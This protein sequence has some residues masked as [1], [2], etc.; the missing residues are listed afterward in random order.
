MALTHEDIARVAH[1]ANR[2]YQ[3]AAGDPAPSPHWDDAPGW[4]R[5][6]AIDGVAKALS[7]YTPEELHTSWCE[8]KR[9]DGWTYGDVKDAEA[10]THPCL[11]PYHK[12]PD[13]QK[14]KDDLF[15]AVVNTLRT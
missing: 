2:A 12:L 6:S 1:E 11:V 14:V 7:G 8:H 3:I 4:Q 10:K 5:D 15:S 9:R 13:E